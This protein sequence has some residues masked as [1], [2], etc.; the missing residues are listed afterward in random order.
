MQHSVHCLHD[1]NGV[2]EINKKRKV[3]N[4]RTGEPDTSVR[5]A[6]DPE[7]G[8]IVHKGRKNHQHDKIGLAPCIK[9]QTHQK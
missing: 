1:E 7:A 8:K 5:I 9:K 3:E 4:N 2:F 6:C